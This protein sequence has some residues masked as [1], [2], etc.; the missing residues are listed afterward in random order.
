MS[1]QVLLFAKYQTYLDREVVET[2]MGT[3]DSKMSSGKRTQNFCC[4]YIVYIT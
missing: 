4:I 3:L 2:W 1:Y